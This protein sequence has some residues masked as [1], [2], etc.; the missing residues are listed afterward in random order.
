VLGPRP[1]RSRSRSRTVP[2]SLILLSS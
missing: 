1:S 2:S